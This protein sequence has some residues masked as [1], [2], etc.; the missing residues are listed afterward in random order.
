MKTNKAQRGVSYCKRTITEGRE[1]FRYQPS[2]T[3]WKT[4]ATTVSKAHYI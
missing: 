1:Y 4:L 2:Q 3:L